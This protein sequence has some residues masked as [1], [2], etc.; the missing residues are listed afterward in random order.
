MAAEGDCAG[1]LT[2]W[3]DWGSALCWDMPAAGCWCGGGA[4]AE[5]GTDD[6]GGGTVVE[7]GK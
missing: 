4:G 3:K 5:R 2:G 6:C 1:M 7:G